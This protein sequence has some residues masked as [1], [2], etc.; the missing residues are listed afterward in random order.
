MAGLPTLGQKSVIAKN[1]RVLP[2]MTRGGHWPPAVESASPPTA[3]KS[4]FGQGTIQN[5]VKCFVIYIY[6]ACQK[7]CLLLSFHLLLYG[8]QNRNS[9]TP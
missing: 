9:K 5:T 8:G 7:L 1:D 6:D 4:V 2:K 3:W